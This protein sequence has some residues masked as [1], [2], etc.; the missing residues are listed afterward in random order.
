MVVIGC[1]F[2]GTLSP[3]RYKCR[4]IAAQANKIALGTGFLPQLGAIYVFDE[5]QSKWLAFH[6]CVIL[7]AA[8]CQVIGQHVFHIIYHC[9]LTTHL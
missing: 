9:K 1:C 8:V 6:P 2:V 7:Q 5:W 4:G 3:G